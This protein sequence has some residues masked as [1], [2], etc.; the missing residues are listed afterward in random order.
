MIYSEKIILT[1]VDGVL[2][3]WVHAFDYWMGRH[4]HKQI[5]EHE[6]AIENKY[7]LTKQVADSLVTQFNES[8]AIGS[9]PPLRDALKYVRKL[10]EEQGFVFH[11]ITAIPNDPYVKKL[12]Q[13]NLERVFGPSAIERLECVETSKNKYP[14][15]A[16]YAETGIPWIE[17]RFENSVMG[18]ELGLTAYIVDHP[19]NRQ[20]EDKDIIRVKN[21]QEIYESVI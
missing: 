10:H 11:C 21:W 15:L 12:R 1:D 8:A 20:Y 4:G 5:S 16:E 6:Y 9:L 19:Y 7:D 13:E 18:K 3:S 17:D 14:I 2:F